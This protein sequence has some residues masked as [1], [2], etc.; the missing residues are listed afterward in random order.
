MSKI[1]ASLP[2]YCHYDF[3]LYNKSFEE[4]PMRIQEW[5]LHDRPRE[6]LLNFGSQTLSD[7]ELLAIFLRTGTPG[8]TAVDLAREL[9]NHYGSL[10][11]LLNADLQDF[12]QFRGLGETKYVQLQ[13]ALEIARRHL[14]ETL[15]ESLD[16]DRATTL[17]TFLKSKLRHKKNEVFCCVFL[18]AQLRLIHFSELFQGTVNY[19]TV[20]PREVLKKALECNASAV[21]LV[22]NHPSSNSQPS[23]D[24]LELTQLLSKALN[25]IDVKV[26]DHII[27]SL[28]EVT[29]LL[30]LGL[31]RL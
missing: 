14:E 18:D 21:I 8:K 15:S 20:Y 31:L 22:H 16:L 11:A 9:I 5:P 1:V 17:Y 23:Q 3:H 30:E 26:I 12:C 7:A 29:S 4:N 28:N 25:L 6:K 10:R 2:R 13:A 19:A 24:D 27:V